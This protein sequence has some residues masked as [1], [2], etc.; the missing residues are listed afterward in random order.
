M[1]C[2]TPALAAGQHSTFR[3]STSHSGWTVGAAVL[4]VAELEPQ[5]PLGAPVGAQL[6][7][8]ATLATAASMTSQDEGQTVCGGEGVPQSPA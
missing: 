8:K 1:P 2:P 5:G 4:V 7:C 3:R 6:V